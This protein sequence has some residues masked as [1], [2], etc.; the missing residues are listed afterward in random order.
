[1]FLGNRSL[2][3]SFV[4]CGLI[5]GAMSVLVL[6][7]SPTINDAPSIP[8]TGN[9]VSPTT[10][11]SIAQQKL[12]CAERAM[13]LMDT[14]AKTG[15]EA[16]LTDAALWGKRLMNAKLEL[17]TTHNEKLAAMHEYCGHLKMLETE[18]DR[19]SKRGLISP[20]ERETLTYQRLEVEQKMANDR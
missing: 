13:K 7:E 9:D 17:A 5:L 14:D 8:A 18:A 3:G 1:M 4:G 20:L 19:R 10:Q 16:S 2:Q 15:L 6:G 11:S 12:A